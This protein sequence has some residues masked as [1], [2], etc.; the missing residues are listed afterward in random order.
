[1]Q[2]FPTIAATGGGAGILPTPHGTHGTVGE[3]LEV[4][5]SDRGTEVHQDRSHSPSSSL[6]SSTGGRKPAP[7]AHM[8]G[9]FPSYNAPVF[10]R[11]AY[12]DGTLGIMPSAPPA[13]VARSL[14]SSFPS[15]MKNVVKMIKKKH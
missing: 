9:Q 12:W 7:G 10:Y 14:P 5:G 6:G 4:S 15:S 13:S 8:V 11:C 1:M 3:L 2:G